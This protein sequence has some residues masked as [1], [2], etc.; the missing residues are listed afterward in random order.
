[1]FL[2]DFDV[3]VRWSG[4][5]WTVKQKSQIYG[6]SWSKKC[7]VHRNIHLSAADATGI[8][9]VSTHGPQCDLLIYTDKQFVWWR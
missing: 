1:M 7:A 9:N 4:K 2:S 5:Y 6:D 8:R 3:L